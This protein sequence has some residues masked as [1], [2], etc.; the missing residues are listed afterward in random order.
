MWP[1][2]HMIAEKPTWLSVYI[3]FLSPSDCSTQRSVSCPPIM[4]MEHDPMK[5]MIVSD[6][7][8]QDPKYLKNPKDQSLQNIPA[9]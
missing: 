3:P 1:L 5:E 7:A 4:Q 8:A 9:P 2:P 6:G